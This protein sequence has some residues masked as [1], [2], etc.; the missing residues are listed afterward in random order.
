MNSIGI[1]GLGTI[2]GV[3]ARGLHAA[4][5]QIQIFATRRGP[6][7]PEYVTRC[8]SNRELVERTNLLLLCVKPAQAPAILEEI[9]PVLTAK[10]V[11]ISTCAGVTLQQIDER[12]GRATRNTAR[13][14]P[15]V[16]CE[17]NAGVTALCFSAQIPDEQRQDVAQLF[18]ALGKAVMVEE[19]HFDAVTALSG[20]GPAYASVIVEA[21]TDAGVKQGLPRDIARLLTAQTLLGSAHLVLQSQSHPAEIRDRVATPG[22]CTIDA[23]TAL[24]DGK[25]RAALISAV[26]AA[27]EKS[28]SLCSSARPDCG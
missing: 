6:G 11:L 24:E 27:A 19:R 5:P 7:A 21:L 23:L 8:S 14:M 1:I 12:I 4:R 26:V 16:P 13:A 3:I 20:C 18:A 28:A 9:A 22:G 2:G 25:L 15:N 10:H 17:L